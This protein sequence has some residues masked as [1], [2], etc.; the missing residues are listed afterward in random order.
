MARARVM[1]IDVEYEGS[2][3]TLLSLAG[4]LNGFYNGPQA[5]PVAEPVAI[6]QQQAAAPL[7]THEADGTAP[8]LD[9]GEL[10][11]NAAKASAP[12]TRKRRAAAAP[13]EDQTRSERAG[14]GGLS[15]YERVKAFLKKNGSA[16]RRQIADAVGISYVT[17]HAVINKGL[18]EDFVAVGDGKSFRAMEDA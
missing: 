17:A 11:G 9:G 4:V 1:A 5:Q 15:A 18:G 8:E 2:D 16:N 14:R 3:E 7:L 13:A 12:K 10:N 6:A